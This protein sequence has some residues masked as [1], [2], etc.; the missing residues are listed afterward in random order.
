MNNIYEQAKIKLGDEQPR[1]IDTRDWNDPFLAEAIVKLWDDGYTCEQIGRALD[2][3]RHSI[4][5]WLSK[6]GY[7]R[8]NQGKGGYLRDKEVKSE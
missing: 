6:H 7:R 4:G 5:S 1:K 8:K 2:I 3:K